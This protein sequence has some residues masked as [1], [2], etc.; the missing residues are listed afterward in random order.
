MVRTE[1]DRP[2]A[3]ALQNQRLESERDQTLRGGRRILLARGGA[4]LFFGP[5]GKLRG[6]Q[7]RAHMHPEMRCGGP[8]TG[9]VVDVDD[10][11]RAGRASTFGREIVAERL[12][13]Y[14]SPVPVTRTTLVRWTGAPRT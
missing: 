4:D 12:G 10:D 1:D 7:Q 9:T 5:D 11:A 13:S 2:L 14:P 3:A 6:A 8:L